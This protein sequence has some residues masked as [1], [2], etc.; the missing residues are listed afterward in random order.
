MKYRTEQIGFNMTVS[1]EKLATTAKQIELS[2]NGH[3]MDRAGDEI[4]KAA[5]ERACKLSV[6]Y[7]VEAYKFDE[8]LGI[9]YLTAVRRRGGRITAT[10]Y[11]NERNIINNYNAQIAMHLGMIK[12]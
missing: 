8:R 10:T 11:A 9:C 6:Y 2:V 5:Q 12:S 3:T 4:I 1:L 7:G